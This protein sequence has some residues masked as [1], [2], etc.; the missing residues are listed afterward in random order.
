MQNRNRDYFTSKMFLRQWTPALISA[1]GL[2]FGDMA[3]SIVLGNHMGVTGLAAISLSLPVFMVFNVIMHGLGLGGSIRYSRQQARGEEKA[4]LSGF[5]GVMTAALLLG[6]LLAVL[7]ELFLDPL[8]YVLGT[9]PEDGELY[10]ASRLYVNYVLR[11]APLFFVCY[12][13]NY[14]LRNDDREKLAGIGFTVGNISDILLNIILVLGFRMGVKGAAIATLVGLGISLGIYLT[15]FFSGKGKLK[16][17][18]FHPDRTGVFHCFGVGFSTSSQ[19]LFSMLF[20]LSAN[21]MLMT[22]SGGVSVAVFDMIQNAS[23]LILYLYDGTA[24]AMQPLVS[25][26]CGERNQKGMR[27]TLRLGVSLGTTAG[28]LA[29][30]MMLLFPQAVCRL[31][32][33]TEG[34]ALELGMHAL[35]IYGLGAFVGGI[36]ILLEGYCQ[37]AGRERNAF[38]ISYL[39]GTGILI[40][41]TF[42]FALLGDWNFWWVFPVTEVISILIFLI[43]WSRNKSETYDEARVFA[44]TIRNQNEALAPMLK[45]IE[46]FCQHWAGTS[47]QRYLVT[48]AVEELCLAI[49]NHGFKDGKGYIQVTLIA[50]EDGLFELHLRDSAVTFN[51]F[52]MESGKVGS[53]SFDVDSV[54]IM[55]V[56]KKAKEFYYRRYQGFNTL[57]VKI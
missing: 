3:D 15:A 23:F 34:G 37:A 35:R 36:S 39:R 7:G 30:G 9:I 33:L 25:N 10:T 40:P 29:I 45:E 19:Y 26:Y 41:L 12:V 11:G 31:F 48:M 17:F 27:S 24:K 42:L 1:V 38:L 44:R 53:D 2:A 55:V 13:F 50:G 51:P 47:R 6:I 5:Q 32:G 20:Y 18:P 54:G 22:F 28:A 43:R 57:I 4:A 8:M 49:M 21:N 16:L 46:E 56:K 52:S 14:F